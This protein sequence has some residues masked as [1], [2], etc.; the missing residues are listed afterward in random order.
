MNTEPAVPAAVPFPAL[1]A[2]IEPPKVRPPSVWPE[3]ANEIRIRLVKARL[4]FAFGTVAVL[5]P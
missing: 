5:K 1:S 3:A 4:S 2:R